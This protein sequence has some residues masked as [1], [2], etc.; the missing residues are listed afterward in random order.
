VTHNGEK[1]IRE[2]LNSLATQSCQ[3]EEIIIVDNA[4]SDSTIG[5]IKDSGIP[6]KFIENRK[7]LHYARAVNQG[8]R[9][10][11]GDIFLILNQD[12]VLDRH[13]LAEIIRAY[14]SSEEKEIVA[15][16]VPQ[17]RF[18]SLKGFI[19]SMGNVI[20]NR[21]W[22]SDNFFGVVDIG[23]LDRLKT[24][25]SSCFGA[26]AITRQGWNSVGELDQRYRSYYED[27]DWC[28]RAHLR[29]MNLITAPN[30]R[31]YHHFG[32]SYK[33]V[34]R[35]GFVVRNR[36][37]FVLKNFSGRIMLG[38][39]K[40]Y[41]H[42]DIQNTW[43]L[44]MKGNFSALV[45]YFGAYAGL[46]ITLPEMLWY[47]LRKQPARRTQIEQF[48]KQNPDLVVLTNENLQPVINRGVIR[49]YYY[50]SHRHG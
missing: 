27:I 50:F 13:C 16:V 12:L 22:G 19:N 1:F 11:R 35:L 34:R 44:L 33:P 17:L 28:F 31:A 20:R 14:Q 15:A 30:A 9:A 25:K 18:F 46:I 29:K 41:I 42:E 37:R 45:S 47:H 39:L 32:G 4:S 3:P 49:S 43:T 2:N 38:F 10:A 7:N 5:L 23:Q 40:N 36:M 6:V 21:G 24:V 26:I 48:F 8:I